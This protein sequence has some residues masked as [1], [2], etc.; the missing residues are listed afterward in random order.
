MSKFRHFPSINCFA[1]ETPGG[2][3][4]ALFIRRPRSRP[5]PCGIQRTRRSLGARLRRHPPDPETSE[6][7]HETSFCCS[8]PLPKA[9]G[10]GPK[11]LA[12]SR[13]TGGPSPRA[14]GEDSVAM[15]RELNFIIT[16]CYLMSVSQAAGDVLMKLELYSLQRWISVSC[17]VRIKLIIHE[18]KAYN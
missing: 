4:P 13:G 18:I 14:A 1:R 10:W 15:R 11:L 8:W 6:D 9:L 16:L 3:A 12:R 5:R 7:G 17:R 2:S